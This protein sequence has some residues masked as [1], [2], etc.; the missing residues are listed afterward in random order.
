MNGTNVDK[1]EEKKFEITVKNV[2]RL[3][4]ALCVVFVFC[5]SFMVS[6][7]GRDINVS[8]ITAAKGVS[9]YG[10]QVVDPHPVMLICLLLPVAVLVL[11]FVKKFTEKK[12]AGI[13]MACSVADF[14]IWLIFRANVKKI[15]EDNYCS[16]KTVG[17]Y[18]I[19]LI[20]ILLLILFSV[21]AVLGKMQMEK[22]LLT[23]FAAGGS[24]EILGQMSGAVGRM[25]DA[26]GNM[27][28]NAADNVNH[29]KQEEDAIGYCAKCGSPISYGCKF[30]VSCGTPV[31]ESML[32]EAAVAGPV[33][34]ETAGSAEKF[35]QNCGAKV[36]SDA[37]FCE[38]CGT[39]AR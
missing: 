29:K 38:S 37:L 28:K 18:W 11:L 4:S 19:N 2:M 26:V 15:A 12:T 16:F 32:P 13:I 27:A 35:C 33:A 36:P 23:Q 39:K 24:R 1:Q 6:C 20:V 22:D 10:E 5:P 31:P 30:C 8:A 7:S 34:E 17:W 3:L 25:S 9:S 21:L 14:A